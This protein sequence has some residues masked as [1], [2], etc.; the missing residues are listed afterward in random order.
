MR[1]LKPMLRVLAILSISAAMVLLRSDDIRMQISTMI[2]NARNLPDIRV[3]GVARA[4]C[5]S[6]V[7]HPK[8]GKAIMGLDCDSIILGINAQGE[9]VSKLTEE[10]AK[11]MILVKGCRV[12]RCMVDGAIPFPEIGIALSIVESLKKC[13][14]LA[15]RVRTIDVADPR[16]PRIGIADSLIVDVGLDDHTR[17]FRR[18]AQ[19][20][21]YSDSLS[22]DLRRVDLRFGN[23]VIVEA[24]QL[25]QKNEEKG[26]QNKVSAEAKPSKM[27]GG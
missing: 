11:G 12:D 22:L 16:N 8:D 17:K 10:N 13:P 14:Y 7:F 18:L 26:K 23:Q 6:K 15:R 27:R 19:I 24:R 5:G 25:K 4:S 3:S 21:A 20:V 2:V 1:N 9:I